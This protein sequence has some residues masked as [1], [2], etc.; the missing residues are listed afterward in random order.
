MHETQHIALI[1]PMGAGKSSVGR[2]LA[3]LLA[4]PF[5]DLDRQIEQ[6]AGADIPWIFEKEGEA[7][8]RRR[9]REALRATLA[10]GG[11]VIACGGGVVLDPDNRQ[12]LRERARV[13]LLQVSIDE[14]CQRLERD[15][16]RPLLQTGD[17]RTRLEQLARDRAELYADTA[18]LVFPSGG[19]SAGCTARQLAEQLADRLARP[20]G[21]TM[22]PTGSSATATSSTA[23]GS[24][25]T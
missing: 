17:L 14:Q 9:E 12:D 15:R 10:G 22:M 8:F 24:P 5:V 13:V 19:G 2:H 7:G 4:R 1:G 21:D 16:Q 20:A 6:H 25:T 11:T 23:S 18:H 3:Q